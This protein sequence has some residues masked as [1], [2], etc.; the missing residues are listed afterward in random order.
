[1]R[2]VALGAHQP[3]LKIERFVGE[4]LFSLPAS[5]AV[6]YELASQAIFP[7]RP[8]YCDSLACPV[9]T[10]W[11]EETRERKM[12]KRFAI[13]AAA[14]A[15]R[16]IPLTFTE[17]GLKKASVVDRTEPVEITAADSED[18]SREVIHLAK[19]PLCVGLAYPRLS[20]FS[21]IR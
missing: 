17:V 5:I 9:A 6:G 3:K 12:A 4:A 19:P 7:P 13:I 21:H 18:A 14:L 15:G 20:R 2:L 16:D 10:I 11:A 1:M 8:Q